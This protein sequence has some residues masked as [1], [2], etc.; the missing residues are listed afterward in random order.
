M[1]LVLA[2]L[3][4]S[5]NFRFWNRAMRTTLGTKQKLGF[6]DGTVLMPISK[7]LIDCF[8][9]MR[10]GE[11]NENS[12]VSLYFTRLKRLWDELGSIEVLPLCSY[13]ASKAM[14]DMN[15]RNRLIQFLMNLNESF[16]YVRDQILVLDP[17]PSINRVYSMALK[18]ESQ[19][20]VLSKKNHDSNETLVLFNQSQNGKQKKYDPKKG[21]YSHCNMDSH[22]RDIC[23]KLIGYPDWFKNKTKI[24]G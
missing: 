1:I 9:Y 15:N 20:E 12:P 6:V 17:L 7:D 22:V 19:K 24:G 16:N 8:I 5:R 23:F 3:I 2:S 21:H 18:Y 14:D 11:S 13:G 4:G 10:F